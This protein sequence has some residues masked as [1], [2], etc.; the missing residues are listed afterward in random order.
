MVLHRFSQFLTFGQGGQNFSS[1]LGVHLQHIEFAF[2]QRAGLVQDS[3]GDKELA[4]VMDPGGK[5]Q[6]GNLLQQTGPASAR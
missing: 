3:F 1:H 6:V 5:G 4:H 2:S